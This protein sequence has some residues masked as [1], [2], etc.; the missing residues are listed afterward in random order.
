MNPGDE[1]VGT[2]HNVGEEVLLQLS[3]KDSF[4][5]QSYL[6]AFLSKTNIAGEDVVLVLPQTFMNLSGESI[7]KIE[8]I[9]DIVK[10]GDNIL[11]VHDEIDIP[12]GEMKFSQSSGA[13][14]H[15]GVQSVIDHLGTQKFT[16][17]RIGIAPKVDGEMRKPV[18]ED[19]VAKFVLKSFTPD[20]KEML[21]KDILPR[22][23]RGIEMWVRD[24]FA[25][26]AEISN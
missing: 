5:K 14:G 18:G 23:K 8:N 10:S 2:R 12:F 1:Y 24:G 11:V 16:R 4:E 17:L 25:K 7:G 3:P 21:E 19:A 9:K 22:V 15:N 26:A 13:G 20:E 6:K